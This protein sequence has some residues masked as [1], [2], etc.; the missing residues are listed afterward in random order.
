MPIPWA[1]RLSC[2]GQWQT[3]A[4]KMNGITSLP[5]MHLHED[6]VWY[7]GHSAMCMY[8]APAWTTM[9]EHMYVVRQCKVHACQPHPTI[10]MLCL[11]ICEIHYHSYKVS[12]VKVVINC[13][14]R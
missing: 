3:I 2:N 11:L 7:A 8:V 12:H 10:C 13:S 5:A 6:V 9:L 4:G 14:L 1:S